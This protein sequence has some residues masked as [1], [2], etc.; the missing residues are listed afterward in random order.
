MK[1]N[2]TMKVPRS[3]FN[4]GRAD[5]I[6]LF[7]LD[8]DAHEHAKNA[9]LT[10]NDLTSPPV[11]STH[12]TK[13]NFR[14]LR[15]KNH[16]H[17]MHSPL[18]SKASEPIAISLTLRHSPPP[19]PSHLS[20]KSFQRLTD[21]VSPHS[22]TRAH[23]HPQSF[24]ESVSSSTGDPVTPPMT[25]THQRP[26][27]NSV[28]PKASTT[29]STESSPV[30][31]GHPSRPY[32]TAIR[33]NAISPPSSRLRPQSQPPPSSFQLGATTATVVPMTST[34][35]NPSRHLSMSAMTSSPHALSAL[36]DGDDDDDDIGGDYDIH[37]GPSNSARLSLSSSLHR[38]S[39]N[40]Y[41]Q[42]HAHHAQS[43]SRAA[44][45]MINHPSSGVGFSMSGETELRMALA[46]SPSGTATLGRMTQ[47]GFRFRETVV[48]SENIIGPAN[49]DYLHNRGDGFMDR[50]KRL[51]RGLKQ[52]LI[53]K[54]NTMTTGQTTRMT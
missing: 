7:D 38:V 3:A 46:T 40:K 13:Q 25:P 10:H 6:P 18:D 52:M 34:M 43:L 31:L 36:Y 15:R 19:T 37:S 32:Y 29:G 30:R 24:V 39:Y 1:S 8:D 49:V 16:L 9:P 21:Y 12:P 22:H 20:K 11:I 35:A 17:V 48:P 2:I 41:T 51:R 4:V 44:K 54:K 45:G 42:T 27:P 33:K 28:P 14:P 53:T 26:P 50:V 23:S 47:D 5:K